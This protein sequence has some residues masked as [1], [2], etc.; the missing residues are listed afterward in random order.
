MQ[1]LIGCAKIMTGRAPREILGCTTPMFQKEANT[2]A[3]L[4]ADYTPEQLMAMLRCN[5]G[6]ANENWLRYRD[7]GNPDTLCPAAF[8]YDG[9]VFQKLAPETMSDSDLAYANEHLMIG[10]FLYGLLR[11]LDLVSPYR[12]EG[13][14]ELPDNGHVSMFDYWKPRLID[15]F[16]DRINAD[17]GV[18]VNLASAEFKRLFDWKQVARELKVI[19]PDFKVVK[20]GKPK[21]VTI[22]AKMCRGA[23]SRWILQNRITNLADLRHFSYEGFNYIN[24]W[25]Y[26]CES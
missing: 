20:D 1:I 16:I 25:N 5:K 19:T 3:A 2:I 10:S 13:D 21:N 7:F 4:L 23:M 14:V 8:S 12:L 15:Y 17:D 26:I 22:Y 18:L 9:M 24:D 6:I 11:P